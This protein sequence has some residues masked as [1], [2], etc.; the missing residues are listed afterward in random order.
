ME[1][2]ENITAKPFSWALIKTIFITPWRHWQRKRMQACTRKILSRL[3]DAQLKDIGLNS[4]D[5][6]DYK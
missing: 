1:F 4:Y 2:H 3:S 6:R 5:V